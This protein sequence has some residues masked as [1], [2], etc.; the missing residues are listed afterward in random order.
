MVSVKYFAW[1]RE[2]VGMGEE[3]IALPAS[4]ETAGDFIDWL[5]ARDDEFAFLNEQKLVVRVAADQQMVSLHD[6]IRG[7]AELA[8]FPPMTGG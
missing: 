4:V 2:R 6:D 1:V 7:A 5:A 3:D 8:V